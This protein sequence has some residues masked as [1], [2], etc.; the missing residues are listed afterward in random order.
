MDNFVDK[1]QCVGH[2]VFLLHYGSHKYPDGKYLRYSLDLV[3][4]LAP[5]SSGQYNKH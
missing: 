1:K 4:M 2:T 3:L 5:D